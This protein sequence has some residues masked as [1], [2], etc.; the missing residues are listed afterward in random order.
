MIQTE[1]QQ[2]QDAGAAHHVVHLQQVQRV[3]VHRHQVSRRQAQREVVV[4]G[5]EVAV[6]RDGEDAEG[7]GG[8]GDEHHLS[9]AVGAMV[10]ENK[11]LTNSVLF[12]L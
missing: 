3:Q 10:S 5:P 4:D 12:S 8:H 6:G 7:G 1:D 11:H 9:G 2:V